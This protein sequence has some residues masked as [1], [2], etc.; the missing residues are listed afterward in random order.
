M[1]IFAAPSLRSQNIQ[2]T[3]EGEMNGELLRI[4][5]EQKGMS[6]CGFT[7]DYVLRDSLDNCTAAYA[8]K[9]LD[10]QK[11]FLLT[12]TYFIRNSGS[13]VLM[14][15]ILWQE[16]RLGKNRLRG[17][18]TTGGSFEYI[19]DAGSYDV[20]LRK[21]SSRPIKLANGEPNCFP[22]PPQKPVAAATPPT[23]PPVP[24]PR[25]VIPKPVVP[26]PVVPAPVTPKPKPVPPAVKDTVPR[27]KP[28]VIPP[29]FAKPDPEL[30]RKMTERR[31][32]QQSTLEVNVKR[33]NLKVYDNGEIDNDTVSIFYNG[34][35]LLSHQR[36]SDKP[37][38]INLDLDEN[39]TKHT[40][41][42]YAENLG[43]IP[44]NTALIVVTA[45]D[46]RYELRSK[47]NL[48]E[49]AVLIFDYKPK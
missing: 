42:M 45:G 38:I 19:M 15:I 35:L 1:L 21:V 34:K 8:G 20:I 36:L 43:G 41:T 40:L 32:N 17:K 28:G 7:H 29:V 44:P 33:I 30:M 24:K 39:I 10:E 13:H 5:V 27:Q 9:Y 2:G 6:I 26:K 47:A 48:E 14:K 4:S 22:K 12:G 16:E 25:P 3:W 31:Q 37:I 23:K 49:N 18:V 46:K 11:L